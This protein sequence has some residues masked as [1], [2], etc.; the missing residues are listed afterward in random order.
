MGLFP[1]EIVITEINTF[2]Q[3]TTQIPKFNTRSRTNGCM[4]EAV[5]AGLL[6][7]G[8]NAIPGI[9]INRI[10]VQVVCMS[11]KTKFDIS[12]EYHIYK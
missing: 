1:G 9:A 4:H 8:I 10:V 5:I 12:S 2:P 11:A 3:I 7:P 6:I